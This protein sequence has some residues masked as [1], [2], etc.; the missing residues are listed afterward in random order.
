[1]L[2]TTQEVPG[3][4]IGNSLKRS[5]KR[6][7]PIW[8]LAFE[9]VGRCCFTNSDQ[10]SSLQPRN[11]YWYSAD[12]HQGTPDMHGAGRLFCLRTGSHVSAKHTDEVG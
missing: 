1:M 11:A 7:D 10:M 3:T 9:R 12:G 5:L 2:L 4:Y 6:R 8:N